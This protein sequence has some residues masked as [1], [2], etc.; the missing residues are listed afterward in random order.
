MAPELLDDLV[1][2]ASA[3]A[4]GSEGPVGELEVQKQPVLEAGVRESHCD[5]R[6]MPPSIQGGQLLLEIVNRGITPIVIKHAVDFIPARVV[7][8]LVSRAFP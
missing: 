7:P 4:R 2:G 1:A 3:L 5:A 6:R 8:Q